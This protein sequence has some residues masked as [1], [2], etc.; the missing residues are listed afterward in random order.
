MTTVYHTEVEAGSRHAIHNLEYSNRTNREAGASEGSGIELTASNVGQVALETGTGT[1][2]ILTDHS[3]ITWLQIP[4]CR[5]TDVLKWDIQEGGVTK[6]FSGPIELDDGEYYDTPIDIAGFATIMLT[7][8]DTTEAHE[9]AKVYFN[10]GNFD[11]IYLSTNAS[12][13]DLPLKMC[14]LGESTGLRIKNNLGYTAKL[15]IDMSY[16]ENVIV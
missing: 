1:Y 7:R 4:A 12:L 11:D 6:Y 5:A 16:C 8:S 9:C 10:N 13:T 2:W 3:P 14:I 15:V